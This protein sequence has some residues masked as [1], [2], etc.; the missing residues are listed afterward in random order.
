M[1]IDDEAERA[2]A[3]FPRVIGHLS[4]DIDR[5]VTANHGDAVQAG[6]FAG[7]RMVARQP[8]GF[9]TPGLI[10]AYER[11]LHDVL[12]RLIAS[13]GYDRVVNVGAGEGYYAV[14]LARRLPDIPIIAFEADDALPP[15]LRANA[16][17]NGVG[18]R[19][20]INGRGLYR[21]ALD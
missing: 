12:E 9:S 19:V 18:E 7:M 3:D 10:G 11:E 13:G 8:G 14:G 20:T 17:A 4:A 15:V 5:Y 6:P 16:R 2:R 1:T 21:L